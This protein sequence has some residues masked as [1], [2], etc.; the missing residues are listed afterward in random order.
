MMVLSIVWF[1]WHIPIQLP[2]GLHEFGQLSHLYLM[3]LEY[4]PI[5]AQG[6]LEGAV[7]YPRSYADR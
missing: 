6:V 7:P 3:I 2:A 5:W 1:L 4:L